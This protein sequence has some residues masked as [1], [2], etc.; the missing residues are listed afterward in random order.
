MS[1]LTH[2]RSWGPGMLVLTAVLAV[3]VAAQPRS[4]LETGFTYQ[5]QL[6]DRSEP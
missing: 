6:N 3:G 4:P 1:E 5:G 2:I